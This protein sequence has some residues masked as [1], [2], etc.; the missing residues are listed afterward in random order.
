MDGRVAKISRL[1][2]HE[3]NSER[4]AHEVDR[5]RENPMAKEPFQGSE[6]MMDRNKEG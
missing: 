2:E 4:A 5:G 3:V 1:G 6:E